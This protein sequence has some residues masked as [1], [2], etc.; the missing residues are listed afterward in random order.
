[1]E[2]SRISIVREP[3]WRPTLSRDPS[4]FRIVDLLLF[5]FQGRKEL[6]APLGD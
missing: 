4:T 1:M 2:G 3:S 6:L 5:A